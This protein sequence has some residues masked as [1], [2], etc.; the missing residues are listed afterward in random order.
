MAALSE[1]DIQACTHPRQFPRFVLALVF[2]LAMLPVLA[3]LAALGVAV[4][5]LPLLVL[6]VWLARETLFASYKGNAILVS[7][8]NYPRI[9]NLTN[10]LK[11]TLG[12]SREVVVFVYEQGNFN[13]FLMRLFFRRAV[14]L[15]SEILETG[16][17]DDEVRW[18]VGRFVGYLRA[19]SRAGPAGW[20]IRTVEQLGFTTLFTLPYDR[21]MVYTGDRL[22]LAAIGGDIST[23][24]SAMQKLLV[25]RLL[26]YSVNP[27]GLVEQ[28]RAVK[29]SIFAFWARLASP[30]PHA[31]A[32]YVDLLAFAKRRYP[33]P[34]ARF[35]A[36]NPGL[37]TDIDWLSSEYSSAADLGKGLA[38][39]GA[40]VLLVIAAAAFDV[41]VY[42]GML[43]RMEQ[44]AK[45]SQSGAE[46]GDQLGTAMGEAAAE[47]F[48]QPA[49]P[50]EPT[51]EAP[52]PETPSNETDQTNTDLYNQGGEN[53][54]PDQGQQDQS[55][56]QSQP[57]SSPP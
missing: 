2:S 26:G 19:Q 31:T 9:H 30:F 10:E 34:Y 37:A 1:A 40:L 15:N 53:P 32:R 43:V 16:V 38:I 44:Q 12:V 49:P 54:P 33:D 55:S 46:E 28:H 51:N 42:G 48:S 41:V 17:S 11:E 3:A 6:A 35:E 52:P 36:A 27:V 7:E 8:L 21:A 47:L 45:A 14:F 24:A 25:G 50:P 57:Q 22:A 29:G 23:A 56:S 5:I 13:A 18:L 39:Y 4:L 20:L